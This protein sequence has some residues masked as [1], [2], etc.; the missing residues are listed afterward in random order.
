[1][2]AASASALSRASCALT[3]DCSASTTAPRS[4]RVDAY[5]GAT[6]PEAAE[7]R[8]IRASRAAVEE[9]LSMARIL[10]QKPSI[11]GA[12]LCTPSPFGPGGRGGRGGFSEK[13]TRNC[14]GERQLGRSDGF[15]ERILRELVRKTRP[16]Q[17][18]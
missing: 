9:G 1:M 5:S 2:A 13:L 14:F 10:P 8:T 16:T 12:I 7:A 17:T 18:R 6:L 11:D 15:E 4:S 3:T